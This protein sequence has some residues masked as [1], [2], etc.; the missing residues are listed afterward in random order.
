MENENTVL[1]RRGFLETLG[2]AAGGSVLIRAVAAMG[3]GQGVVACGGSAAASTPPLPTG[4]STPSTPVI[5]PGPATPGNLINS[6]LDPTRIKPE[7]WPAGVGNGT[8]VLILGAGIAGMSAA[9][10]LVKL[11]YDCTILEATER[12]GGR[13]QTIRSGDVIE[14]TDSTQICDFDSED[15]LYF[16]PGPARI[17]HHHENLLRYCRL[18]GVKLEPFA[19]DSR[20]A[21][22]HSQNQPD[23]EPQTA[24]R[25]KADTRG[26][27]SELLAGI[28]QQDQLDIPLSS[29]DKVNLLGM[30]SEFGDLN[31]SLRYAGSD[32]AGFSGQENVGESDRSTL[33]SSLT[34]DELLDAGFWRSQAEFSESI[35]QQPMML[36]PVGGMDNIARAFEARV[37]DD[38]VFGAVVSDITKTATGVTVTYTENG[39]SRVIESDYCVCTIP[40]SVLSSISSNI[41]DAHQQAISGFV[42]TR[43]NK[44]AFQSRRFWEQDHHIYGGISWTDQDITQ[45]WYPSH[46]L[47]SQQGVLVG[48]YTFSQ[49]AGDRFS[50]MA[51]AAR[52]AKA[53]AEGLALHPEYTE[54]V[55]RG[56]SKSWPK[57]PYQLGAWGVSDPGILT[58]PDGPIHFAGEHLSVLQGW[59][60]GAILSAYRAIDS[61]VRT[62]LA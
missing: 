8:R 34:L 48:A 2:Q 33:Q 36:Q 45:I 25:I 10:E 23:G 37:A 54:E 31:A 42:Y 7:D 41:S 62:S 15:D 20:G 52:V 44:V 60:E 49:G 56:I 50:N 18:F 55:S 14:E 32:R 39:L 26:K 46:G 4:G 47:G 53:R 5:P 22:F 11:G 43:A 29:Q 57:T 21:L 40:A 13:C 35:N 24:R 6:P 1:T 51:P 12:A 9:Y 61:I 16:N 17:P 38:I 27:I 58:R 28:V 59:Q 3:I 19:N 30:L